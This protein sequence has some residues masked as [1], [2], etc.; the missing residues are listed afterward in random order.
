M[1]HRVVRST[2]LVLSKL[3]VQS[4]YYKYV[5]LS[6]KS[7]RPLLY[8]TS[9]QVGGSTLRRRLH[10]PQPPNLLHSGVIQVRPSHTAPHTISRWALKWKLNMTC[11]VVLFAYYGKGVIAVRFWPTYVKRTQQKLM[12]TSSFSIELST[13]R[14]DWSLKQYIQGHFIPVLYTTAGCPQGVTGSRVIRGSPLPHN[15]TTVQ[16]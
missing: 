2:L 12:P 7:E 4:Q 16:V 14:L 8:S 3:A 15:S 1:R 5:I 13:A 6:V 9:S 11:T 10:N